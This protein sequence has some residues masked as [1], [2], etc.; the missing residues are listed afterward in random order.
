MIGGCLMHNAYQIG[1]IVLLRR[2]QGIGRI[3]SDIKL[4]VEFKLK[5]LKSYL[6]IF[7]FVRPNVE[8][9]LRIV[10]FSFLHHPDKAPYYA[11]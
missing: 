7:E 4:I 1:Q 10:E 9:Q 11:K 2:L 8:L 3:R 6:P 5:M